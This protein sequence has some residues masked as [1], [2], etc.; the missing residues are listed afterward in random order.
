MAS[1]GGSRKCVLIRLTSLASWRKCINPY[2]FS[3]EAL[4]GHQH[5]MVK[6]PSWKKSKRQYLMTESSN[7][8]RNF[9]N[10]SPG[11][12][13]NPKNAEICKVTHSYSR[14]LC[15]LS[16]QRARGEEVFGT[17]PEVQISRPFHGSSAL[18]AA[19]APILWIILKP[20]QKLLAI[21]LGRSIRKWWKALPPDKKELFKEATRRNKWKI[22]LG[23]CS[24]GVIFILFYFTHLEETPITGRARLLVFG[25]E[26]FAELSQIEYNM[27]VEE[28]KSRM[29]PER[30]PRYQVVKK[31]VI[32]LADS[33]KD[34]PEVSEF[35][36]TIHVVEG[37]D[38]NAFVFPNGHVFVFTGMLTAVSDINQLSFI[39]GHEIAHAV[40]GH[41]AEKASLA[42]FLDFLALI[43]LI[44]IW[45]VCPRD[46]LAI[47]GQWI[48]ARFQELLFDR[49]YSRTLEAEADKVGLQFA[50]KA[51]MD[52]RASSVFWQQMELAETIKGQPRLPEW[53][54]THPSH[55]N[56]AE[57]LD[58]LIP[59]AIK[60]REH[61]NCPALPGKDPRLIFKLSVQHFLQASKDDEGPNVTHNGI[62]KAKVN[63]PFIKK[64]K[65]PVHTVVEKEL[66]R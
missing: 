3:S 56:R 42:H 44:M 31:A 4:N 50:A 51:C 41:A 13:L 43:L 34:V 36:W 22:A 20:A 49:P 54:S 10:K 18:K 1:L 29:L 14:R 24:L 23:L 7:V 39:L 30:D 19:P 46:S 12:F 33:N 27:W 61:C 63:L 59:E 11:W 5:Q 26:Q 52:I 9:I 21:I 35:K 38:I 66:S 47:I 62:H 58:R 40:L 8:Y 48:Q 32:H 64:E 25:K 60:I 15:I 37:P 28:F 55:E 2:K 6:C 53:L 65:M 16:Q 57:H 45:A 17:V